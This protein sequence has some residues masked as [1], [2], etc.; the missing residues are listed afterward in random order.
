ME[1]TGHTCAFRKKNRWERFHFFS[2]ARQLDKEELSLKA[3]FSSFQVRKKSIHIWSN[4][5]SV[6][7]YQFD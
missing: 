7:I 1:R 2:K 3:I 6:H 4:E 5:K